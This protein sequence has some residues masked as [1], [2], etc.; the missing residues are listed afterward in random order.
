MMDLRDALAQIAEIRRQM[1]KSDVFR[2][3]RSAPVAL[4]GMLALLAAAMQPLV[5]GDPAGNVVAYLAL[6]IGMAALSVVAVAAEMGV[7][8]HLTHDWTYLEPTRLAVEQFVPSVVAGL[9]LTVVIVR[10][11]PEA[12]PLLPGLWQVMF[13]LGMF[14]SARLLPRPI[15]AVAGWYLMTGILVLIASRGGVSLSPWCMGGPFAIG[16]LS[17]AAVLYWTLERRG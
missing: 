17:A 9:L 2:G 10:H 5:V 15:F 14:A 4:S 3:Y 7:R 8:M 6:W 16:Q 12:V 13:S 1:A 11:V